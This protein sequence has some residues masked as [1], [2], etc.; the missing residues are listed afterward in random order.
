MVFVLTNT[1]DRLKLSTI[2]QWGSHF[3]RLNPVYNVF[4]VTLSPSILNSYSQYFAILV[5]N[6]SFW[7]KT[8]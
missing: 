1:G 6:G 8:N 5:S 4:Y 7:V 2:S 3:H